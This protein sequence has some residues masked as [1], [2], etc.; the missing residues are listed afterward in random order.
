MEQHRRKK[1]NSSK[2]NL[3]VSFIFHTSLVLGVAYFAAREG[4][5]GKKLKQITVTMAPKEKKPEPPKPKP[6][7][8]KPEPPKPVEQP[9]VAAVTAPPPRVQAVAPPP[10]EAP[11]AAAPAAVTLPAFEFNDG[12][13]DVRTTSDPKALYKSQ[14]EHA[15]GSR[16]I[17]P[18]DADDSKFVAEVELT[19]DPGGAITGSRWLKGNG[20][21]KWNDSVKA[22]VSATKNVSP[23][24]KGFP[25]KFIARFDVELSKTESLASISP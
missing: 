10:A 19:I 11:V 13:K 16:W 6:P 15:L 18:E 9:K 7:E 1:E 17:R 25:S 20:T 22:A 8:Q 3:T 5:L 12:A 21:S 14:I 24:P 4:M 2:V 23:P